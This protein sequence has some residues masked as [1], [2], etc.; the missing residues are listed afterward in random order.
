MR[1]CR[2]I[3]TG[4]LLCLSTVVSALP[5]SQGD[6]AHPLER[7]HASD[8]YSYN[9][10]TLFD[11]LARLPGITLGQQLDGR[12]EIQLHGI[13]SRYVL[14]LINGQPLTGTALNSS[15]AT[16]QIPASLVARVDIDR[17]AR[18]DLYIG[19]GG[20]GTINVV[21]HD[22]D[23]P[24]LFKSS[25]AGPDL[26]QRQSL[27]LR[28]Q[29]GYHSFRAAFELSEQDQ[30]L[31]GI[32]QTATEQAAFKQSHRDDGASL[33][34]NFNSLFNGLHPL[35]LYALYLNADEHT[36]LNGLHPLNTLN[37]DAITT[38]AINHAYRSDRTSQRVG[39]DIR[40][41]INQLSLSTF[42]MLEQFDEHNTYALRLPSAVQQQQHTEDNRWHLG[43]QLQQNAYEH[44][45]RTGLSLQHLQRTVSADSN[46]IL[47]INNERNALAHNFQHNE[48]RISG[49]LLDRWQITPFT[50]FEAGVHMDNY[51]LQ[52]DSY[53][54]AKHKS[55]NRAHWLPAFHLMHQL[56]GKTR[57]RLS[58]S[59]STRQPELAD[60][61]PYD[62]RQD[63]RIWRGNEY[64]KAET[65]SSIDIGYEH[66]LRLRDSSLTDRDSG[67]YVRAF[68]RIIRDAI[69]LNA[70]TETINGDIVH[71]FQ[72][73]NTDDFARLRGIEIDM[74]LGIWSGGKLELGLGAYHSHINTEIPLP[75]QQ[76]LPGQPDHMLRL[77]IE[78]RIKAWNL[79]FL[80]RWQ[81]V[82]DQYLPN[83]TDYALQRRSALQQL[84][85]YMGYEWQ[86]WRVDMSAAI[87]PDPAVRW[88]QEDQQQWIAQHWH[89]RLTLSGRF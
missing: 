21:L 27:A 24:A 74:E 59:Q 12:E 82:T 48:Y 63:E 85:L 88:Q 41:D 3:L 11:I 89:T 52:Q 75:G 23:A 81:D 6:R 37:R 22:A 49:F 84:D 83:S 40:F 33:L 60:R 18:S 7:Y 66:N 34:L 38:S 15:L 68:Q 54:S 56:S 16:R 86:R 5:Q 71:I 26:S 69:V 65:I 42:F 4:T 51:W 8:Y 25:I 39:G 76:R 78:H 73:V 20:G 64:L 2:S 50:S 61:I 1:Q 46:A 57:L 30:A 70:S 28:W 80:W 72:P 10:Q 53:S 9:P 45:W 62:I 79:G 87:S 36:D 43:W 29:K 44:R 14:L 19:G 67:I 13:D 32:G 47:S 58:V 31:T 55:I 77:G 35:R 17:N